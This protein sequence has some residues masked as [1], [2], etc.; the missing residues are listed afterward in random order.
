[1]AETHIFH[2]RRHDLESEQRNACLT[3]LYH[4]FCSWCSQ[5]KT[6]QASFVWI[7][8]FQEKSQ[9]L[10]M[11]IKAKNC[12]Y[13]SRW[14]Q[15][16]PTTT[17]CFS[18]SFSGGSSAL[19]SRGLEEL[20]VDLQ[21]CN[22]LIFAFDFS[23]FVWNIFFFTTDWRLP[24][25]NVDSSDISR[26]YALLQHFGCSSRHLGGA[27]SFSGPPELPV[28]HAFAHLLYMSDSCLLGGSSLL[29]LEAWKSFCFVDEI[30]SI[31]LLL[32]FSS[33]HRIPVF[34]SRL[35]ILHVYLYVCPCQPR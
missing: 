34:R 27:L 25:A 13:G 6:V 5:L 33:M 12:E 7:C 18:H 3:A 16:Q 8:V 14:G 10:K 11:W 15:I 32:L 31:F 20:L 23:A 24:R 28:S 30:R 4:L 29:P 17:S 2:R 9:S 1:M 21:Q 26:L 35:Y 22:N 19:P